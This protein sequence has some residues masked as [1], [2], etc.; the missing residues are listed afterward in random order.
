MNV[1]TMDDDMKVHGTW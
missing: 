1:N